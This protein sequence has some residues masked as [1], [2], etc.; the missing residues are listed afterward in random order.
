MDSTTQ[1][2]RLTPV[3]RT[4]IARYYLASEID[5]AVNGNNLQVR[6]DLSEKDLWRLLEAFSHTYRANGVFHFLTDQGFDWYQ[7]NIPVER[8]AMTGMSPSLNKLI[9]SDR[10]NRDPI[11]L[12][13]Y[14]HSYFQRLLPI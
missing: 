7:T 11:K 8:I 5:N 12:R 13:D 6:P 4:E 3:S 10:I 14:L 2:L 9:Q 1:P